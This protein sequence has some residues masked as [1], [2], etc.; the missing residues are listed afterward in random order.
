[1]V[2]A[3]SHSRPSRGS[4]PSRASRERVAAGHLSPDHTAFAK[5]WSV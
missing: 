3:L 1:M 2:R 4:A 5:T